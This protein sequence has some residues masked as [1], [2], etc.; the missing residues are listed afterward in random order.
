MTAININGPY[1]LSRDQL[2]LDNPKILAVQ[3]RWADRIAGPDACHPYFS[4][5]DDDGYGRRK[6]KYEGRYINVSVP[7]IVIALEKGCIGADMQAA[8]L[9]QNPTCVNPRHLVAAPRSEHSAYDAE[10]KRIKGL[11][12]KLNGN[13]SFSVWLLTAND[14]DRVDLDAQAREEWLLT[15]HLVQ[16]MGLTW[17]KAHRV[18]SRQ[19]NLPETPQF[20]TCIENFYRNIPE[21]PN[22]N[23][24]TSYHSHRSQ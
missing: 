14:L 18:A 24:E 17:T 20:I 21:E 3:E 8:H 10:L 22:L 9:C 19:E 13:V 4:T 6:T 16:E 5:K 12:K 11:A 1:A 23:T 2:V 7:R 15:N